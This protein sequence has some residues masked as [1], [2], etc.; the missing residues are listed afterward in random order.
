MALTISTSEAKAKLGSFVRRVVKNREEIIIKNRGIPTAVLI[1][2][3][4]YEQFTAWQKESRRQHALEELQ[5]L[6][7]TIQARNSDLS[8]GEI[9]NL[10]DRFSREVIDE[11]IAE[12]KIKYDAGTS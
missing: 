6:A 2:Y 3:S 8:E 5:K 4:D 1:P 11:M 9:S 12:G 10:A 7:D